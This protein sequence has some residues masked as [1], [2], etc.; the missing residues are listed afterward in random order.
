MRCNKK[1]VIT[2]TDEQREVA[3]PMENKAMESN[4]GL[5]AG[6]IVTEVRSHPYI[7]GVKGLDFWDFKKQIVH[8]EIIEVC[9]HEYRC[10]YIDGED[11][12]PF[13]WPFW[14]EQPNH[15]FMSNGSSCVRYYAPQSGDEKK[16]E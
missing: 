1:G 8:F 6:D 9:R 12:D 16:G 2:M 3:A 10:R 5:N 7:K 14:D 13:Y 11:G 4:R 15:G